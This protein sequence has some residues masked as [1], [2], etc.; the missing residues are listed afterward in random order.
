MPATVTIRRWTGSSGAPVKTDITSANTRA[1]TSD[2]PSPGTSDPIPIPGA[3]TVNSFWVVTR[4]SCDVTPDGTINN[5][6]WYSDGSNSLGTGVTCVGQ[7]ASAYDQATGTQGVN[8]DTLNTT[9]YPALSGA[10]ASVFT[11]TSGSPKAIAGSI[12]NPSTGDFGDFF[13][14]QIQV[15]TTASAGTTP[16]ETFT[17]QYDET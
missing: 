13:V 12:T 16:T 17:W 3:G 5:I 15:G 6:K 2:A 14:Y 1:S 4:L 11:F 8:G 7:D 9:N 10:P